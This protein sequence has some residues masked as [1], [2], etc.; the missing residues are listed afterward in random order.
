[1]SLIIAHNDERE[2]LIKE[3]IKLFYK[4]PKEIYY[5]IMNFSFIMSFY[6]TDL[7]L[8]NNFVKYNKEVIDLD[9]FHRKRNL[10]SLEEIKCNDYYKTFDI[11]NDYTVF[12]NSIEHWNFY[13]QVNSIGLI[14]LSKY[15]NDKL[16]G[17][18]NVLPIFI[19]YATHDEFNSIVRIGRQCFKSINL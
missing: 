17:L 1:M 18:C 4:L 11:N 7:V 13:H 3:L 14:K 19:Q 8:I 10:L 16:W 12:I 6:K 15:G 9:S 2:E 5:M